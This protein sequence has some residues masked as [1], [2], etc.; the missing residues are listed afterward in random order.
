MTTT[1]LAERELKVMILRARKRAGAEGGAQHAWWDDIFDAEALL[2]GRP[3]LI[4]RDY[5]QMTALFERRL[6]ARS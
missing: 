6:E 4:P 3:M 2:D 1:A 5:A